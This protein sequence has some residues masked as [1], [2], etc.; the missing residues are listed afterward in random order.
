MSNSRSHKQSYPSESNPHAIK[1][2]ARSLLML[3]IQPTEFSPIVVKHP[4]TDSGIVGL[5]DEKGSHDMV[6]LLYAIL[7]LSTSGQGIGKS[8]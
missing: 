2:V 1:S 7:K 6:N 4:F 3:D 5:R 8:R